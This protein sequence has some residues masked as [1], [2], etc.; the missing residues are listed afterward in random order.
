MANEK[1]YLGFLLLVFVLLIS[2]IIIFL[3]HNATT[4]IQI[5][6]TYITEKERDLKLEKKKID[7]LLYLTLPKNV[8]SR[9]LQVCEISLVVA[10]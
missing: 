2:P 10:V 8:A 6:S 4:T 1:G 7:N 9:I 3:V 5:F